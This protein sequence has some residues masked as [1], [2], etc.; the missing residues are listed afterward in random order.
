MSI[1]NPSI[2]W[3]T[4]AATATSAAALGVCQACCYVDRTEKRWGKKE[5]ERERE[6]ERNEKT[7]RREHRST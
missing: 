7:E 6:R 5:K 4:S 2:T 1:C 3:T